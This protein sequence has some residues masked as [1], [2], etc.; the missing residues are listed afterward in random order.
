VYNSE[1]FVC[2]DPSE[3]KIVIGQGVAPLGFNILQS[4]F[5]NPNDSENSWYV[6]FCFVLELLV[7]LM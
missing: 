5:V 4:R 3:T 6:I 7:F 1:G 2:D